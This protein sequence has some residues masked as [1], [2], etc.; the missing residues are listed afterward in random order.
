[1]LWAEIRSAPPLAACL[2]PQAWLGLGPAT[3][4]RYLIGM[5][6]SP[7]PRP[8]IIAEATWAEIRETEYELAILPWGAC[9]AHNYHLPYAT[10]NY[11]VEALA[12]ES[13]ARA[14]AGGARV[15]VL[16][17]VPFGV[18]TGQ[19]DIPFCINMNPSTQ[20]AVLRDVVEALDGV[21]VRKLA[22]LNGHGGND[23]KQLLRELQ[24]EFPDTLLVTLS[25]FQA[26]KGDGYFDIPGDHAD[27]RE[28]S[29][30]MHV[31]PHLVRP[32]EQA[33]DGAT[34]AWNVTAIREGW[35]WAQR[36]WTRA[37]VDTG[38]GDPV[39]ASADKG[40]RYFNDLCARLAGL[41]SELSALPMN[42]WYEGE[43]ESL[44][45]PQP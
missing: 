41:W 27:E 15:A 11:Q 13:A 5:S 19:L 37:T 24:A 40:R 43:G 44:P 21:G 2:A 23:F 38:S 25:W 36:A 6:A 39:R 18:N 26:L 22:V 16:P 17:A 32:L 31:A 9:E 8:W 4:V 20:M 29:L 7:T 42:Q 3:V 12:A 35:A 33:G 30:M 45:P 10:D 34:R 1:M 28:T 14:W